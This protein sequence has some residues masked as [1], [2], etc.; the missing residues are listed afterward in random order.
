MNAVLKPRTATYALESIESVWDEIHPLLEAHYVEIAHYPDIALAPDYAYYRNAQ[1][2]GK[3]RIFTSRVG[4]RLVGYAIF[5]VNTHHH[6]KESLQ[7]QQDILFVLPDYRGG[8]VG[9]KLI[10]Y[11]E[12]LLREEDVQV[13]MHHCKKAHDLGPLFERL[14]Y[15]LMDMIYVRRLDR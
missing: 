10:R 11:A 14:G 9:A 4:G 13:V 8:L 12:D 7:A 2:L 1:R 5:F 15:E 3:L 6:Y